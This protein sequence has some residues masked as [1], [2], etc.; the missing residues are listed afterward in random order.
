[1]MELERAAAAFG[2]A[3]TALAGTSD[4]APSA[5][6]QVSACLKV[7][8]TCDM[9]DSRTITCGCCKPCDR[10]LSDLS[11][12]KLCMLSPCT[13][14]MKFDVVPHQARQRLLHPHNELLGATHN[15][16]AD[17]LASTGRWSAAAAACGCS[18]TALDAVF[19]TGSLVVAHQRQK[20]AT[21]LRRA[22]EHTAAMQLEAE[23]LR[24]LELHYGSEGKA[25]D[26]AFSCSVE[27]TVAPNVQRTATSTKQKHVG[28]RALHEAEGL[29]A[30][31]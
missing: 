17:I 8:L 6:E 10:A 11:F 26:S 31:L 24:V 16:L 28:G 5:L 7:Q 29:C 13:C 12:S 14:R 3:Q 21:L 19:P 27:A 18:V 25:Y 15:T 9:R 1:M 22:G 20:H 2:S 30:L 4:A 23:L